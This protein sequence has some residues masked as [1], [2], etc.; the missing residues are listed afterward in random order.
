[1]SDYLIRA[2][3][4]EPGVRAL[5]CVATDLVRAAAQLHQTSPTVTAALGSA[6]VGG[7]LMGAL[8]KVQQR[9]ALKFEG[10]GPV[11]K[12]IVES[13]SYGRLH[14]YAGQPAV[15]LPFVNGQPDIVRLLGR[16]GLL[17]VNKDVRLKGVIESVVPLATSDI[18]GDLA[19]YLEQSEQVPSLIEVGA[20]VSEEGQVVVAGGLLCQ[21]IPP[22]QPQAMEMLANRIQELPPIADLLLDVGKPEAVLALLAT[23]LSFV[24]I[25]RRELRFECDCSRERGMKALSMLGRE[26]LEVMLA[27]EGE[28]VVDCHFCHRRYLFDRGDLEKI[29]ADLA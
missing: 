27:N 21:S 9:V 14:G 5:A 16:A 8:L 17:T 11:D 6:L 18:A 28:A 19:Y 23:G 15:D 7:A 20:L 3:A 25:E 10:T 24:E 1:M 29:L 4:R 12:I 2:I 22:H 26:E 13:D